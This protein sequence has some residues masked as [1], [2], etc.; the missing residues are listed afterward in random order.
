MREAVIGPCDL[1]Q[2]TSVGKRSRDEQPVCR[3]AGSKQR[4]SDTISRVGFPIANENTRQRALM[5]NVE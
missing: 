5:L 1:S 3:G 2:A 4:L